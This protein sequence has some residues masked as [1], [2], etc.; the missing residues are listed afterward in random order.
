MAEESGEAARR[1]GM[2]F[3]ATRA[4]INRSDVR[5]MLGRY[6]EAARTADAG[7]AL[8]EQAGLARTT[9]AFMRGNRAEALLRLGRWEEAVVA[10]APGAEAAGV[11]A[12]AL[13]LVRAEVFLLTGRHAEAESDLREA[14]RQI[15]NATALQFAFPLTWIEAELARVK[16]D[17]DGAL[18]LLERALTRED[19]GEEP[20]YK[21]PLLSL[22][23]AVEA[24]R[25]LAARDRG[26][27]IAPDAERRAGAL[28]EEAE[29]MPP[30]TAADRGQ[31]ALIRAEH[32][33]LTGEGEPAAW[34][35]A[36]EAWASTSEPYPLACALFRYAEALAGEGDAAA[37]EPA[38]EARE[39]ARRIGAAPLLDEV[40][41]LVRRARLRVDRGEGEAPRES[42]PSA[43]DLGLTARELEVLQL[44]A[45]GHS[46][47]QIAERL[48][49]SRKTAS[50]H[51]SNILAKL[52]VTTRVQA[53]AVAHRRGLARVSAE[54]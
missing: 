8:A 42:E 50:V 6:D 22:A 30:R 47:S 19:A 18:A 11:Y 25:A 44:V 12:G 20:R 3:L 26:A 37:A 17:L 52:G 45:E 29:A 9:G 43:P 54:S 49:I 27:P 2:P 35:A 46:N 23:M 41:A 21:W 10:A 15:R 28:R 32:A 7:M 16:G 31:L 34:R 33:R 4:Y 1:A 36:V 48:F 38:G 51:V 14:R 5:L 24:E 39:I 13:L 53:A 40:E